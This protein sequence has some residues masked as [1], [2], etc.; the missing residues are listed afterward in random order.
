M[1]SGKPE[2][3]RRI[4]RT[5]ILDL[6]RREGPLSRSDLA[7]RTGISLPAV[8]RTV[9]ELVADLWVS[10]IGEG[11]SSGGRRPI[12]LKFNPRAGLAVCVDVTPYRLLGCVADLEGEILI[13]QSEASAALGTQL[14]HQVSGLISRLIE[15]AGVS[16][17]K[18]TG[19]GLA[20][21][22]IPDRAGNCVSWAPA[23]EWQEIPVADLLR[24]RFSCPVVVQNDVDTLLLGEQWRG[25]AMG[26]NHAV[27]IDVGSGV[28][29]AILVDGRLYRGRNGAVGE[30]G[31]WLTNPGQ[32]PRPR[33]FGHLESAIALTAVARKWAVQTG[34][35]EGGEGDAIGA[36]V[37]SLH[38]GEAAAQEAVLE[39][40][41][42]IG[43]V[44]A[45]LTTLLNPE[46]IILGGEVLRLAPVI[47]P[48]VEQMVASHSPY[49]AAVV[50]A[51]LGDQSKL[52]GAVHGL[53]QQQRSSVSYID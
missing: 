45:N 19:I 51:R 18:L 44:A 3:I 25:A 2:L 41:S 43:T 40:A 48:E 27:A 22:G 16:S 9:A 31:H 38:A 50:P 42:W 23:L 10:E 20:V 15:A 47:L 52:L 36:M 26:V 12:V 6:L 35:S 4:N 13:T 46:V 1:V 8:S 30:I 29:A 5:L 28:G 39:M 17:D 24:D 53:L 11:V 21:P 49:P 14:L 37:A 7:A 34:W 33:G 32:E